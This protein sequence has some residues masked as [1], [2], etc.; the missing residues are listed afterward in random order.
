V[1]EEDSFHAS[2]RADPSYAA[3]FLC[4]G[5]QVNHIAF[6]SQA[7]AHVRRALDGGT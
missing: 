4:D 1:D 3:C 7:T 6:R 2:D 5:G